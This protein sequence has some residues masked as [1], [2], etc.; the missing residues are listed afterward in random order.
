LVTKS[1][2]SWLGGV[3][4][5]L[6]IALPVSDGLSPRVLSVADL[7]ALVLLVSV[8]PFSSRLLQA[9]IDIADVIIKAA[10]I[11]FIVNNF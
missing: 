4:L 3:L 10:N 1:F 5:V 2:D 9:I 8:L 11:F 7:V 6:A